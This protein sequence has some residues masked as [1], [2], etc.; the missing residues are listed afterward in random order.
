MITYINLK[1]LENDELIADFRS[2]L[3]KNKLT[4]EDVDSF[5]RCP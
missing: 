2:F 1:N 5:I 3:D 4:E